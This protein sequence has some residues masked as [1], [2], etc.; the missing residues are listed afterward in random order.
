MPPELIVLLTAATPI[1]ELRG[2]IPV[3]LAMGMDPLEVWFLAVIGNILPVPFILL[4]MN[5]VFKL[6]R[7]LPWVE[8]FIERHAGKSSEKLN[9]LLQRW[10]WLALIV[11][12]AIPLPGTGAWSGALAA[13]VLRLPFLSSLLSIIAG[14]LG[15]SF[16]ISGIGVGV[17][18]FF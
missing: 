5:L 18:S 16:L 17:M 15:A 8:S 13:S 9:H 1:L 11:F 6:L 10:G 4:G 12:V 2:A 3:G 14:V 7:H